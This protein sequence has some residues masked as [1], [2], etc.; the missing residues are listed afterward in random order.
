MFGTMLISVGLLIFIGAIVALIRGRVEALEA[1]RIL[2]APSRIA[3]LTP[4]GE[5]VQI[6]GIVA[7]G[8]EGALI[9]PCTGATAVW[10]RVRLLRNAGLA[11]AGSEGSAPMWIA[12]ED[13]Q[14]AVSF[15]INDGSGRAAHVVSV[16][17]G[18]VAPT[19]VRTLSAEAMGRMARLFAG[20]G[21]EN[22]M[23]DAYEEECIRVGDRVV[24]NGVAHE[25]SGD[26]VPAVYRDAASRRLIVSGEHG[27]GPI[28]ASPAFVK[29]ALRSAHV[30]QVVMGAGV[31]AIVVG[32]IVHL[33]GWEWTP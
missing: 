27:K 19:V 24:V 13:Q 32:T 10:F 30:A 28:V 26:P 22:W 8:E 9:A 18:L 33:A 5:S 3:D 15:M 7:E 14:R 12:A 25:E 17:R 4:R 20:S 2:G 21:V 6:S 29:R 31:C 1:K 23:A 11:A 16:S